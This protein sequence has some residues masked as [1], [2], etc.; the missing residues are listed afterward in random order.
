MRHSCLIC[1]NPL[2]QKSSTK[3]LTYCSDNC[4]D[5]AKFKS[6]L[7]RS[8]VKLK[9]IPSAVSLIRGDMFRLANL[10]SN[11]TKFLKDEKNA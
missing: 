10:L 11:G 1:G 4:R 7:E 6:A 8:I 3:P 5:Y 9:P 2:D